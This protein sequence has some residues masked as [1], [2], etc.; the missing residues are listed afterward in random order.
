MSDPNYKNPYDILEHPR[1]WASYEY[2][3][4]RGDRNNLFDRAIRA[5]LLNDLQKDK[6]VP[7]T[8]VNALQYLLQP[9]MRLE[10][11]GKIVNGKKF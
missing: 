6:R 9:E 1:E 3:H 2:D 11:W 10:L 7:K 8:I 4:G 5:R